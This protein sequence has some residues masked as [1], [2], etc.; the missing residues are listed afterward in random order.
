M[1]FIGAAFVFATTLARPAAE[2]SVSS[3]INK[4]VQMLEGMLET[5]KKE[6]NEEQVQY[7]AFKQWCT[8]ITDE[9]SRAVQFAEEKL[10]SLK[11]TV[12]SLETSVE[13]LTDEIE[14]LDADI[15]TWAGDEKAATEVR[16]VERADYVKAHE[17]Y[18]ETIEAITQAVGILKA[19][20]KNREQAISLLSSSSLMAKE[21][22]AHKVLAAFLSFSRDMVMESPEA[23]AYELRSGGVIDMLEQLKDKFIDER[24]TLE[25]DEMNKRHSYQMLVQDLQASSSNA[26]AMRQEKVQ[27][28][29]KDSQSSASLRG[30]ITD[31]TTTKAADEKFLTDTEATCRQKETD[32]EERQ[33]LRVDEIVAIQKAIEILQDMTAP[34]IQTVLLDRGRKG[35]RKP[36]SLV[37]LLRREVGPV[38]E[39]AAKY[40]QDRAKVI[41][42][43]VLSAI[44]ERVSEDPFAKVK[45]L[46]QD[47][48]TRLEEQAGEEMQHKAWCDKEVSNNEKTRTK[49]TTQVEKL[50]SQIEE[51]TAN[52]AQL[53]NEINKLTQQQAD[54][55][56]E[57]A[58]RDKLYLEEKKNN[59]QVIKD[60][61]E[62]QT[63]IQQAMTVLKEFY[64]QAGSPDATTLLQ[65]HSRGRRQEPATEAETPP[66][67]FTGQYQGL[68]GSGGVMA[69]L[70]TIQSK[71]AM[72]EST[73]DAEM[74]TA[75][76]EYNKFSTESAVLKAQIEKDIEHKG[77]Q[78]SMD[79]QSLVDL[80]ND[81]LSESKELEAAENYFEKLKPSCLNAGMS[82]QERQERRQQEI[83]SLQ[84]ALRILSGEDLAVG[85]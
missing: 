16:E 34:H 28:K 76:S 17:D 46:I 83:Q 66:E 69:M 85:V 26:Q 44:A 48:I 6:K 2:A 82:F 58:D 10:D 36:A 24:S 18:S 54:L 67:I 13:T 22:R 56:Q 23:Y 30:D 62:A 49:L 81:H 77:N 68:S 47:L 33:K 70:E 74:A 20:P 75:E 65:G 4:V 64:D 40:L 61:K 60:A 37:Q 15:A 45:K 43:R 51:K 72:I 39:E 78:K 71:Y 84:E 35:T 29:A 79:E 50:G 55:V 80:Q 59:E 12:Q 25:K 32:F 8:S 11:A 53:G 19:Q 7:A 63:A 14:K 73:T 52:I 41:D 1:K 31:T 5:G 42:S 3:P 38:Q 27:M 9:K 57:V 21:V